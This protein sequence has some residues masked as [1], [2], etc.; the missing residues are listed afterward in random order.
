MTERQ[1][2]KNKIL[3]IDDKERGEIHWVISDP[4]AVDV[5]LAGMVDIRNGLEW[6]DD[7]WREL[8]MDYPPWLDEEEDEDDSEEGAWPTVKK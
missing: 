3:I 8:A 4:D 2:K 7:E 1:R 5:A 6:L